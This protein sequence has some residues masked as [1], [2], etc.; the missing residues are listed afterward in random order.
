MPKGPVSNFTTTSLSG[1]SV[2]SHENT[3][4]ATTRFGNFEVLTNPEGGPFLLGGGGFGKTYKARHVYLNQV[5]AL[6]VINDRLLHDA[7][8]KER[9]L[10]EAQ[11]VHQLRHPHIA[12]VLDFGEVKHSL[13]YAME[14]CGGGTL[15]HMVSRIGPVPMPIALSCAKQLTEALGCAHSKGFIHR[16]VKPANV[17]LTGTDDRDP[18][19][20]LVD[21]GLVKHLQGGGSEATAALTATGQQFFTIQFASPEQL[22][23]EELDPRS[24]IF[25]LGMTIWFLLKG[26]A[27]EVGSMASIV[28]KRLDGRSYEAQ[29]PAELPAAYR[30]ILARLLEKDRN[31]RFQNTDEVLAAIAAAE[32]A[33][34]AAPGGGLAGGEAARPEPAPVPELE[35]VP[36]GS[37]SITEL[38]TVLE[39]L[40]TMPLGALYRATANGDGEQV[41]IT[42]IDD[43]LCADP[44]QLGGIE[45]NVALLKTQPHETIARVYGLEEYQEGLALVQEWHRGVSLHRVLKSARFLSYG[46][47]LRVLLP[48]AQGTDWTLQQGLPGIVLALDEIYLQPVDVEAYP[49]PEKLLDTPLKSWPPFRVRLLPYVIREDASEDVG[50]TINTEI[51]TDPAVAFACL[52]YHLVAGHTTRAAAR[53]SRSAYV[54]IGRFTEDSNRLLAACIASEQDFGGCEGILRALNANEGV[55]FNSWMTGQVRTESRLI[56]GVK[57]DIGSNRGRLPIAGESGAREPA[58]G[59][60]GVAEIRRNP[61]AGGAGGGALINR[62]PRDLV[63]EAQE[64]RARKE[65][66]EALL[67]Q[68]QAEEERAKK[69]AEQTRLR[70]QQA[71]E[72][73][74][75]KEAADLLLREK[76]AE[77]ARLKKLAEEA[78]LKKQAEEERARKE[79]ADLLLKQKQAEEAQARKQAEE[80][81]A[82]KEAADLLLKQ[83]QAEEARLKKLADE[84]RARKE[85]EAKRLRQQQAEEE[86]ARKEAADLL[87]KQKQAEEAK[88]KKLADEERARKEAE[89]KRLRQQQAEEERAKKEAEQIQ[90]RQQQA[91]EERAKKEAADLLL[92]QKQA[93]EARLKKLAE[94]ARLKKQ[95]E[96]ERARK[97]AADLL[98]KQK[99]AEEARARKQAE[100]ERARKEAADLLLKQKQAEEAR[101]KKLAEEERARKEA[102]AKQLRKQ[103][104]EEE[105]AKKEAANLLLR[106]KQAEEARAKKLADEERARK[107]A[108]AKQL[109]R[110]QAEEERSRKEAEQARLRQ[111]QAEEARAKKL[112]LLAL[113]QKAAAE[114]RRPGPEI[115]TDEDREPTPWSGLPPSVWIAAVAASLA[116]VGVLAFAALHKSPPPGTVGSLSTPVA[117]GTPSPTPVAADTPKPT[118]PAV[119]TATPLPGQFVFAQGIVPTKA[120]V[121][122]NGK[123]VNPVIDGTRMVVPLEGVKIGDSLSVAAR[124]YDSQTFPITQN[125]TVDAPVKL[126]RQE[127]V[128][129]LQ[130]K[131]GTSDYAAVVFK[132]LQ[133]LAEDRGF[134]HMDPKEP[135]FPLSPGAKISLPTGIYQVTLMGRPSEPQIQGRV[136]ETRFPVTTQG[137][138]LMIPPSLAGHYNFK[139]VFKQDEGN[140]QTVWRNIVLDPGLQTGHVDDRYEKG[141]PAKD[142]KIT[143]LTLDARG[144]LRGLMRFSQRADVNLSYD[145]QFELSYTDSQYVVVTG[146][147]EVQPGDP[148]L[149]KTIKNHLPKGYQVHLTRPTP[150]AVVKE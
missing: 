34:D 136:L 111:Q 71:E 105:R 17:M 61:Q 115:V 56:P 8:A 42:M 38:Y 79:A 15:E 12:H 32:R 103:Q 123:A 134:V 80:E 27:P 125:A 119:P 7:A 63:R 85:A 143:D 147:W 101:L 120:S 82:R 50:R 21:F 67:R 93:E 112:A 86:R 37:R 60:S 76:Q 23:E 144:T 68:Q 116:L 137:N 22:M 100:E 132:P 62:P 102:E 26:S 39:N 19:L 135:S 51:V 70:Q 142:T 149:A 2:D 33:P 24:D 49:E 44:A 64:L 5:V 133:A 9:F 127:G 18:Q 73:R 72:E 6:K 114:A 94:E 108:E 81:R 91:E 95:A 48:I 87:L 89:A 29:L 121:T 55:G 52:L 150:Q 117:V 14:F 129:N 57:T 106:Q 75:R 36:A 54:T 13:Y 66:E 74:V 98:L 65:A 84:E 28:A 126:R 53:L 97:E 45:R 146:G 1:S 138:G 96:E 122:L 148:Q 46:D 92:R 141:A 11:V 124:G 139:F 128:I 131:D 59:R 20:K 10:R 47:A 69:E 78:R 113:K 110:Q 77:E 140:Q 130:Y 145:E 107:E 104:A 43:A 58:A 118:P 4:V 25:A 88:A 31:H 109:R 90:L 40:G 41:A 16:D 83:K 30:A 3:E 99:Q 35:A